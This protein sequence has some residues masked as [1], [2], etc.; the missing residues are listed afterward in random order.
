MVLDISDTGFTGSNPA[1]GIEVYAIVWGC[2]VLYRQSPYD[3]PLTHL[4]NFV[5]FSLVMLTLQLAFIL[6]SL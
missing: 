3:G 6:L 1:S 2:V 5:S 4:I